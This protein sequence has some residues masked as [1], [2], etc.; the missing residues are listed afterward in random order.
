MATFGEVLDTARQLFGAGDVAEA[1][2]IYR[3]LV[4]AV[5]QAAEP[6]H[7]LGILYAEAGHL[8]AAVDCLRQA[9]TLDPST[10]AYHFTLATTYR[11]L[12]RPN[13]EIASFQRAVQCNMAAAADGCRQAQA[14][15]SQEQLDEAAACLQRVLA[16]KPDFIEAH[17]RLGLIRAK[18]HQV[19]QAIARYRQAI[20][21]DPGHAEAVNYLAAAL[22]DAKRPAEAVACLR[23][24]LIQEPD[25]V[26]ARQNLELA[27]AH[28]IR[29]G[30][31]TAARQRAQRFRNLQAAER[32]VHS[33]NGEDGVLE[34]LFAELGTTN[35]F[36][37]EFGCDDGW[38]CNG[39]YL[40]EQGW[41]GLQM[42]GRGRSTNP[43]C[44]VHQEFITAENVNDVFRKHNVPAE[45]DLLSIDIDGNDFWVWQQITTRPRV[46]VIEYNASKPPN[47]RS[48]IAY[49]PQF[50]WNGSDYLGASLLALKELGQRKGYTLVYCERAGVNAFFVA[51]E[52][53]PAGFEPLS[54]EEIYRLP[55]YGYWGVRHRPET[56][57]KMTDPFSS[58]R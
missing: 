58:P 44:T 8:G 18:Q 47:E 1:E 35:H 51:S 9:V 49:D 57:R 28:L 19:D 55:N 25:F 38:E 13:E 32:K 43:R 20:A 23:Q 21:F 30:D 31:A 50:V 11:M 6:W 48:S 10:S 53:L 17:Y 56:T 40:L 33:Q 52:L 29:L 36:F 27:T 34:A 42:D 37:V 41:T 14:L 4:E 46:V 12:K 22:L 45:F 7:E 39:A 54:I 26:A 15:F 3:Q 2:R 24:V 16:M 5:P